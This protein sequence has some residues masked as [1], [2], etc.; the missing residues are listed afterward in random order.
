MNYEDYHNEGAAESLTA[1]WKKR[2][3]GAEEQI[4]RAIR[5][6]RKFPSSFDSFAHEEE[7][8]RILSE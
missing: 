3:I 8:R 7:L 1:I 5:L 2:F 4:E 6:A